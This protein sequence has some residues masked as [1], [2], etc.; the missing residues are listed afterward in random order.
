MWRF[1]RNGNTKE[2]SQTSRLAVC[3]KKEK[4]N[5]TQNVITHTPCER[6]CACVCRACV[7]VCVSVML[8]FSLAFCL[9][10][11]RWSFSRPCLL[12]CHS[13]QLR[14]SAP[15]P[16]TPPPQ[17][18]YGRLLWQPLKPLGLI[19]VRFALQNVMPLSPSRFN[20][21]D[22]KYIDRNNSHNEALATFYIQIRCTVQRHRHTL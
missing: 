16:H 19:F 9:P 4:T 12:K 13:L 6:V 7:S 21:R 2:P 1:G 11:I 18:P 10:H 22:Y 8:S 14:L 15:R 3:N 5:V 20:L 17:W